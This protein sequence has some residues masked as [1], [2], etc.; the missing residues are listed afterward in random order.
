M[1]P[2][3]PGLFIIIVSHA[4]HFVKNNICQAQDTGSCHP[5]ITDALLITK[6]AKNDGSFLEKKP[7]ILYIIGL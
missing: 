1:H 6:E 7:N 3:H 2:T 5:V 4:F